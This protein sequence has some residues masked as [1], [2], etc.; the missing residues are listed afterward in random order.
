MPL[1]II[2]CLLCHRQH[3]D[4]GNG[5]QEG[6]EET[7]SERLKELGERDAQ[8]EEIEEELELIEEYD[9]DES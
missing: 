8:K 1:K 7:D 6:K 2:V 5:S 9:R 3:E 4:E